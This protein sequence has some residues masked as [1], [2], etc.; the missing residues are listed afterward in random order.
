M[1][2]WIKTGEGKKI[3][4]LADGRV[5]IVTPEDTSE[6]IPLFCCC[7]DFPMKTADDS[8]SYRKHKICSQCDDRWT[9]KPGI[10]WP[11]GPEKTSIEWQTYLENRLLLEK[12]TINFK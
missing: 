1:N 12:P 3:K 5:A 11:S 7:C 2:D 8:I 9:S 10:V 4:M 6:I